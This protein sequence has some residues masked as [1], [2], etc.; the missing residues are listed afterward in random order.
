VSGALIGT[1]GGALFI[2]LSIE[3]FLPGD[4]GVW[5]MDLVYQDKP[6]MQP[7]LGIK[8]ENRNTKRTKGIKN[9][10]KIKEKKARERGDKKY[11][12]TFFLFKAF[13]SLLL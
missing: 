9:K 10:K 13:P 12:S 6:A 2:V 11:H 5:A 3:V 8:Q 1:R 4:D 7:P